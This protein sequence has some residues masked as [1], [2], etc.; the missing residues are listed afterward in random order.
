MI[1]R[2]QSFKVCPM[3]LQLR[4]GRNF[5]NKQVVCWMCFVKPEY[6][7]WTSNYRANTSEDF[8]YK[9]STMSDVDY[10]PNGFNLNG[11]NKNLVGRRSNVKNFSLDLGDPLTIPPLSTGPFEQEI[12]FEGARPF[13][14]DD[15]PDETESFLAGIT[16]DVGLS[17]DGDD[18]H[19]D[20]IDDLT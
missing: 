17:G 9:I 13:V 11:V 5:R 20:G 7:S 14:K 3:C 18:L 4:H 16:F 1:A 2:R 10:S 15:A 12:L 8:L 6:A 19:P